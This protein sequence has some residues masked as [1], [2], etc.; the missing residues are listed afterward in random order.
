[1]SDEIQIHVDTEIGMTMGETTVEQLADGTWKAICPIGTL[2]GSEVDGQCMGV[3]ATREEA[4]AALKVDRK[5]L[6]E[7]MW[8]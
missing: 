2:F 1:M 4:L 5:N 8:I 7:S 6:S 3:G